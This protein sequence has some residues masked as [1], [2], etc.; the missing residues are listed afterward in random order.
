MP[1]GSVPI[2]MRAGSRGGSVTV[3][4]VVVALESSAA[5]TSSSQISSPVVSTGCS[6]VGSFGT[7]LPFHTGES[8]LNV[9]HTSRSSDPPSGGWTA[10]IRGTSPVAGSVQWGRE[11]LSSRPKLSLSPE[12]DRVLRS[13]SEVTGCSD[14]SPNKRTAELVV[15]ER[16]HLALEL[17]PGAVD[18]C[19]LAATCRRSC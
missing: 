18:S 6:P 3:S 13:S 4:C 17:D 16:V 5:G 10:S 15:V 7:S 2:V 9:D 14:V 11:P 8:V 12:A 1:E 19:H